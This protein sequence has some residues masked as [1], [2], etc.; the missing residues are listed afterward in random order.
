MQTYQLFIEDIRSTVPTLRL[1]MADGWAGARS[2]ANRELGEDPHHRGVDVYRG[3]L[4]LFGV[5]SLDG[6]RVEE[7][8]RPGAPAPRKMRHRG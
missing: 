3:S 4:W 2:S 8:P 5:G 1:V 7:R 6:G